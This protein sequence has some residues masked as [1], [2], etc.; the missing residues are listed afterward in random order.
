M[1]FLLSSLMLAG[2]HYPP[3]FLEKKLLLFC[4]VF[5]DMGVWSFSIFN[6]DNPSDFAVNF[7]PSFDPGIKYLDIFRIV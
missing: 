3:H 1:R 5:F 7:D 4:N 6:L 2:F